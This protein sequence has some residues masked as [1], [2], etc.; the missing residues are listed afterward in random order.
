MADPTGIM[1]AGKV[2]NVGSNPTYGEGGNTG[3]SDTMATMRS[4]LTMAMAAYSDTRE[5]E[6]DDLRFMAGSPDNQWQW[7]ADVLATRGSV[8]GQAINAR[9][10]LTINKLPQPVRQVTNEQRQNRPS[11]KVI[12]VDDNADIEVAAILDGMVK[13]IEYISDA[14]VAY[15]TACDNQV[16]YGEGYIRILTDYCREDSFDQD[17]RSGACV[18]PFRSTWTPRSKTLAA[19]TRSGASSRRI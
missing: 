12:P 7:P 19:L 1:N 11:G 17:S 5:D 4:R 13:H 8:Q 2:A 10:C 14:D 15:D 3:D 18:T 9:P 16:T 6:L